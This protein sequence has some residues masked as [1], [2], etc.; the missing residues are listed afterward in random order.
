M[1]GLHGAQS[2]YV[3]PSDADWSKVLQGSIRMA[4]SQIKAI[5]SDIK[6]AQKMIVQ[7]EPRPLPKE[8]DPA[9]Q[10]W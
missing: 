9:F 8:G 6:R 3:E 4:E 1:E 2:R 10:V 7:W 5:E